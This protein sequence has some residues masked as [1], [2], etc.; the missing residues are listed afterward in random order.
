MCIRGRILCGYAGQGTHETLFGKASAMSRVVVAGSENDVSFAVID[1]T[2]AHA[3]GVRLVN[4]GFGAGCHV[5]I[6]GNLAIAGNVLGGDVRVVDVSNPAAPV[7]QGK[8][9]TTMAGVGAVAIRKSLVV[10]GESSNAFQA[11]VVLID[12]SNPAVPVVLGSTRTPLAYT[13]NPAISSAAFISDRV[14]VVCGQS[15]FEIV[16]VDF[17]VPAH[18]VVTTFNPTLAG[19]P[20]IDVDAGTGLLAAGDS[21]SGILKWFNASSKTLLGSF[22]TMLPSLTSVSAS[23][24]TILVAS[25]N[26]FNV[27]S[28]NIVA[29]S[30]ASLNPGLF[31]GSVTG[32]EGTIGACGAILGSNV[33]LIDLSVTPPMVLGTANATIPSISTVAISTFSAS[34]PKV[35]VSPT[36]LVFGAV[37][38]GTSSVKPLTI[39]NTGNALLSVSQF[40]S[41]STNFKFSPA[42]PLTIAAGGSQIVHLTFTPNAVKAFTGSFT[43]NTND[44]AHPALSVPMSGTG[45]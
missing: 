9:S 26:A 11:E 4:A 12:V 17:T 27:D 35:S 14:V 19:P 18:P 39:T 41:T 24:P 16:Q 34:A 23:S 33:A 22:N 3:P 38:V 43:M 25:A 42:G 6:G 45:K 28:V 20:V 15:D 29:H 10:A 7:L 1:F 21:T 13:G 36:S 32:I 30:K 2:N 31:G 40:T 5:T 44:P 37:K 8:V